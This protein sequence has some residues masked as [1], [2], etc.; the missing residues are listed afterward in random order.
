MGSC[1][2][3]S[4]PRKRGPRLTDG[5]GS[6]FRGNDEG[7]CGNDDG[8]CTLVVR[9]PSEGRGPAVTSGILDSGLRRNDEGECGND[10]GGS[11]NDGGVCGY[12]ESVQ[13][14]I[15][16]DAAQRENGPLLRM[17]TLFEILLPHPEE[18]P[19]TLLGA[20]SKDEAIEMGGVWPTHINSLGIPNAA[21]LR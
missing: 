13:V 3:S 18:A 5:L 21:S 4:S 2:F 10:E 19:R 6:R 12:G 15:L 9:H 8:A 20:V 1:S 7:V 16:R 14:P 11:G 17:R